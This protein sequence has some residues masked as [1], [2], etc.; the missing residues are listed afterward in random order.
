MFYVCSFF[1]N[2]NYYEETFQP[3]KLLLNPQEM[4]GRVQKEA[5]R[6]WMQGWSLVGRSLV[7]EQGPGRS[8]KC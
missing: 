7:V 8:C 2:V 5:G 6:W 1:L 4:N 3:S